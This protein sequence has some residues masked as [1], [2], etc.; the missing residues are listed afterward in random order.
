MVLPFFILLIGRGE[1]VLILVFP[2]EGAG[3]IVDVFKPAAGYSRIN[4]AGLPA[5]FSAAA[6]IGGKRF[7]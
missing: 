4:S 3:G 5:S 2:I 1:D 6:H 7:P